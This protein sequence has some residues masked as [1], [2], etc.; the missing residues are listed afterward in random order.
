[1]PQTFS[2]Q[3]RLCSKKDI[4]RLLSKGRFFVADPMFRACVLLSGRSE[5]ISERRTPE[6]FSRL[7]LSVPKR[8]FKRAV[9]RN[10]LK[11]RIREAYRRHK[12]SVAM[13]MM[14]VYLPAEVHTYAEIEAALVRTLA[15][16]EERLSREDHSG[17]S[18]ERPSRESAPEQESV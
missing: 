3:E 17:P 12:P 4:D 2:K 6:A 18:A 16:A 1:M 5:P 14:L 7:L 9:K 15:Q 11:R 13:D 10:L 8:H